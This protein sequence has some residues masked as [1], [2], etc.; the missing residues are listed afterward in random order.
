MDSDSRKSEKTTQ[1]LFFAVA[2]AYCKSNSIDITPEADTGNG[3][4]DFKFSK[5][6]HPKILVELKLS[7]NDVKHG[8]DVQLPA[9]VEAEE[10]DRSHYVV[11]DV[12]HL[13]R[14][15]A[16]LEIAR[17]A[18]GQKEPSIWL[19]DATPR[20]SASVRRA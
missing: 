7:K 10:A 11:V 3:P 17:T 13:G 8:H 1:R 4:V 20:A 15:W 5:G 14:K 19:V 18:T 9:Y 2:Y 6:L 16:E 12:G